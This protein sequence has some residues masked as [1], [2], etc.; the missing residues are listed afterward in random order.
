[1]A[2]N[3]STQR[4]VAERLLCASATMRVTWAKV[5]SWAGLVFSISS[6]P[7]PLTV[8]ANTSAPGDLATGT[9]SPV[10]GA[11]L[12]LLSPAR[13]RPSSGTRSPGWTTNTAP[14]ATSSGAVSTSRPSAP[15]TRTVGGARSIRAA[16][17]RR[18]RPALQLSS[19]SE[20]ANR[21]ETVAA[22]SQSP[23]ATAPI[24]AT[25][26]SRF[27]SGRTRRTA[28]NALGSTTH[29]PIRMAA[30]KAAREGHNPAPSAS[31]AQPRPVARPLAA[32]R[33]AWSLRRLSW[34]CPALACDHGAAVMP[35]RATARMMAS[36]STC[37]LRTI[38]RPLSTS[39]ARLS[40]PPTRGPISALR[41][42]TSSTQSSPLTRK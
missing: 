42:V 10:M 29:R 25:V 41:M 14:T 18:A 1:M 38:I 5:V 7:S 32:A 15:F 37:S 4:S 40:P 6:A 28:S 34:S 27:I 3:L 22:S 21:N 24:T 8:P 17:A 13:T 35:V 39:K 30:A 20:R 9:L 26:I 2:A 36:S 12:T 23:R 16:M 19:A 11:W 33:A 31:V